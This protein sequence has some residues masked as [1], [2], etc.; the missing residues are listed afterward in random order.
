MC[1]RDRY[2]VGERVSV[3]FSGSNPNSD[4]RRDDTY[5]A[6]ER[7]RAGTWTREYDDGDWYTKI[8]FDAAGPITTTTVEWDIPTNQPAGT[9][10]VVLYGSSRDLAGHLTPFT[11]ISSSFAV[12]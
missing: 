5:L 6:I 7:D 1:I 3:R 2:G 8:F 10:R 12:G 9:Y 4:L 11:G